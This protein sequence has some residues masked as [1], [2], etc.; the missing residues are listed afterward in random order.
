[1][2]FEPEEITHLKIN[3][4]RFEPGIITGIP[5]GQITL[6]IETA[7]LHRGPHNS[8]PPRLCVVAVDN[9]NI[10]D[11]LAFGQG[12]PLFHLRAD[13]DSIIVQTT[14]TS[15][16][17]L[18]VRAGSVIRLFTMPMSFAPISIGQFNRQ[19][20]PNAHPLYGNLLE[21]RIGLSGAD[22]PQNKILEDY[23]F[24]IQ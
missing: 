9:L 2:S 10:I 16:L 21:G 12:S 11:G 22:K 4:R 18:V 13:G 8:N 17:P 14:I 15:H 20:D 5:Y 7:D 23:T 6:Q 3:G 19:P 1:M 24:I